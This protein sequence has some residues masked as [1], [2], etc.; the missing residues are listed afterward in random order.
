[1]RH[2]AYFDY[3]LSPA[4]AGLSVANAE[5]GVV[6]YPTGVAPRRKVIIAGAGHGKFEAPYDDPEWECW[7]LNVCG[8]WDSEGRLRADRWFELHEAKAQSPDDME[9]ISKCPVPIYLP[10]AFA[11]EF[12]PQ[13]HDSCVEILPGEDRH[14][15]MWNGTIPNAMAFPLEMLEERFGGYWAC[16]FAYQMALALAEGFTDVGL[17]GVELA[18]GTPRERTV[19]WACV[20]WWA[21]YLE[22]KGVRLHLPERSSLGRHPFRYGIEY[23]EEKAAVLRYLRASGQRTDNRLTHEAA[24]E[25]MGG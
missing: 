15:R 23:D 5:Q 10:R 19:E 17:Y 14:R 7:A 8:A 22:A 12:I 20:S 6:A 24:T 11:A 18:W 21:G 1:M 3:K 2:L 9:W 25:G 13:R 16:T 4:N